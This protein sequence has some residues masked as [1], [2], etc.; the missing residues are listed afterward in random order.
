VAGV[1]GGAILVV[2]LLLW[3]LAKVADAPL[4]DVFAYLAFYDRHFT[5]FMKGSIHLR[6]TLYYVSVTF[7]SLLLTRHVLGARRWR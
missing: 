2:L 7:F 6:D 5:P 3:K 4:D 1:T